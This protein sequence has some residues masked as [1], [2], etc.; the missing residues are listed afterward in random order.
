[1]NVR[2]ILKLRALQNSFN[3]VHQTITSPFTLYLTCNIQGVVPSHYH[4]GIFTAIRKNSPVRNSLVRPSFNGTHHKM[5]ILYSFQKY[6]WDESKKQMIFLM[7]THISKLDISW[8]EK[9]CPISEIDNIIEGRRLAYLTYVDIWM[10]KRS[11]ISKP[12]RNYCFYY[13]SILSKIFC[14]SE[15]RL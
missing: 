9:F 3:F 1:M 8:N 2:W 15:V 13:L 14:K 10:K 7:Q 4:R 11:L 5:K 12:I 6:G